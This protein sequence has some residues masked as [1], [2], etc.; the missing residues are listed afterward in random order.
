MRKIVTEIPGW[1]KVLPRNGMLSSKEFAKAL[2]ISQQSFSRRDL[3]GEIPAA[4]KTY[5]EMARESHSFCVPSEKLSATNARFWSAAQV[6]NYIRRQI[7]EF[8][9]K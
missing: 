8:G 2:G 1:L 4:A 6:R 5:L 9:Q 7:K 3:A